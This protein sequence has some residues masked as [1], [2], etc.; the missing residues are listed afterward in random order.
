MSIKER[1]K[2]ISFHDEILKY[3][4]YD[5]KKQTVTF[6][7]E[8]KSWTWPPKAVKLTLTGVRKI[9][10]EMQGFYN[11]QNTDIE[12]ILHFDTIDNSEI[13]KEMSS[14]DE[15][16]CHFWIYTN[17][18]HTIDVVCNDFVMGTLE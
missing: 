16:L 11:Y 7:I 6:Y 1:F 9:K 14:G 8:C 3:V 17:R 13:I 5:F 10:F 2:N 18:L 15:E 4:Y 12:E